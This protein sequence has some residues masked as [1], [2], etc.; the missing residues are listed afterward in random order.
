MTRSRSEIETQASQSVTAAIRAGR[1]RPP[2]FASLVSRYVTAEAERSGAGAAVLDSL[3]APGTYQGGAGF[4]QPGASPATPPRAASAPRTHTA[5]AG[6][7]LTAMERLAR[8]EDGVRAADLRQGRRTEVA[9]EAERAHPRPLVA[10]VGQVFDRL[11]REHMQR[12]PRLSYSD[13][14]KAVAASAP[15][16]YE[17]SVGLTQAAESE[18][19]KCPTCGGKGEDADGDKCST[20]G[21]K[22]EVDGDGDGKEKAL[23]STTGDAFDRAVRV[24]MTKNPELDYSAA[25]DKVAREQRDLYQ[26]SR[27]Q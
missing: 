8:L 1:A 12:H 20:C 9:A 18:P 21:G 26:Q 27:G 15:G 10:S 5:A 25:M 14:M 24:E 2:S 23:L 17:R 22:G 3:A 13:A 7:P 16:L 19:E 4:T 11:V 6:G